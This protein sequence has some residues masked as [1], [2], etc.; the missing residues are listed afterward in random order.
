MNRGQRA[1][2]FIPGPTHVHDEV[3][4]TMSEYPIG[5][6]SE[7]FSELFDE[8]V[9]GIRKTLFTDSRVY[10]GTCSATGLMEAAV[11]NTVTRRC[12]NFICGAFSKRWHEITRSCG[13]PCDPF[14][15]DPGCSIKPETVRNALESNRY[16]TITIV[17]NETSTGVANPLEEIA[18]TAHHFDDV[19][20]L[21]DMVSSMASVKVEVDKL[22][23]DVALASVQKG[24]ALPPGF[25]LCSVSERAFDASSR[26]SNK[27]YYFDFRVMDEF[28]RKSQTPTTPS[29]P[30]MYALRTQLRR[31]FDE[32][33]ENR[34]RRHN[35]MAERVRQWA[36]KNFRL[37]A[38][39]G[40]E[41]D[42]VTCIDNTRKFEVSDL[43]ARLLEKGYLISGGYGPLKER[44]FRIAHMGDIQLTEIDELLDAIDE[45]IEE[46]ER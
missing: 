23:I 9:Q 22:G 44:T 45:T 29:I 14:E 12:A 15:V 24:W 36:R 1:K 34:F 16:D 32:G 26:V 2:L 10:L 4:R 20:L 33:L 11:R 40:F 35:L 19:L 30:H 37:F 8:I 38:E 27:G 3:L 31:I 43:L 46:I 6:R 21:V 5:H 28:A 39:K 42:T 13:I 17:H 18:E 25:A 41:S 7:E